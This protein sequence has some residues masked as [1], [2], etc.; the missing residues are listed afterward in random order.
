MKPKK[1]RNL[2]RKLYNAATIQ[3]GGTVAVSV[4][5]HVAHA[6]HGIDSR[7]TLRAIGATCL[8]PAAVDKGTGTQVVEGMLY[9][10]GEGR[11]LRVSPGL[12]LDVSEAGQAREEDVAEML[13]SPVDAAAEVAS[14]TQGALDRISDGEGPVDDPGPAEPETTIP[15]F[16]AGGPVESDEPA[17]VRTPESLL[18]ASALDAIGGFDG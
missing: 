8:G 18:P 16:H 5:C 15:E 2:A 6:N 10:H 13:A 14:E 11:Y 4:A 17:V 7:T 1:A 3:D 9:T 12:V